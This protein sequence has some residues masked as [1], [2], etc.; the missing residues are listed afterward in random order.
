MR[1]RRASRVLFLL[2]FFAAC[3]KKP[4]V[5]PPPPPPPS[6]IERAE[7]AE[8]EGQ[9][10]TAVKLY[11][12]AVAS[13]SDKERETA[14][15]RLGLIHARIG[16]SF[17]DPSRAEELLAPLIDDG[18][19]DDLAVIVE[20]LRELRRLQAQMAERDKELAAM[21]TELTALNEK[22]STAEQETVEMR[23][24]WESTRQELHRVSQEL[25]E[26]KRI[27]RERRLRLP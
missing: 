8:L 25:E 19:D 22:L 4:A 24:R 15:R 2:A 11:E 16:T 9:L 1:M 13:A 14:R 3:G 17:W 26:L 20:L 12:E 6:V 21:E 27:D 23:R 7:Q 10:P 18:A 5:L